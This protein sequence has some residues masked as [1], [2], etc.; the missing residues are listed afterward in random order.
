[1]TDFSR[2]YLIA[3]ICKLDLVP[4]VGDLE[5]DLFMEKEAD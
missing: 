3:I 1:M 4:T 2:R 5:N